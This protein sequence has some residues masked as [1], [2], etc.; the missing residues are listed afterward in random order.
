MQFAG[1]ADGSAVGITARPRALAARA[2]VAQQEIPRYERGR[3]TPSLE[4]LRALIAA[5]GLELTF[6]L[7]RADDSYDHQIAQ[8]LALEPAERL[9]RALCDAQPLRAARVQKTGAPTLGAADVLGVLEALE[10]G[11][12]RYVLIGELA[13]VL[14]GSPLLPVT[15]TVTVV[16]RAGQR[17]SLSTVIA[18]AEGKPLARPAMPTIDTPAR[19]MLK[20]HGSSSASSRRRPAPRVM[21]TSAGTLR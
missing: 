7:A 11:R 14:H 17:E 6:G 19:F 21:T 20:A 4:R 13:E 9:E 2:G 16:P 10:Q 5:C 8:A 18:G 3:V 12:V 15:G 1:G